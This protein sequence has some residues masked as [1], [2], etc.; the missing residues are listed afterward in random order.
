[1]VETTDVL[2]IHPTKSIMIK[3]FCCM[4]V[5][6]IALLN[7]L[8]Q[9]GYKVKGVNLGIEKSINNEN[10]LRKKL[11]SI[12]YKI[13]YIDLHWYEHSYGAIEIAHISKTIY[14]DIP[15]IIGGYTS[16]IYAKQILEFSDNICY[17]LK[18]DSEVPIL[19]L[20]N[21]I[22]NGIG[23]LE[24]I[25]NICYRNH[26]KVI[27]KPISY[28]CEDLNSLDY[29][30]I[31][32]LENKELFYYTWKSGVSEQN[33]KIFW[34]F[35]GRGCK[36]NCTYCCGS[37]KNSIDLFG[38]KDARYRST[39]KV[40]DDIKRL[41]EIGVKY[42]SPTLDWEMYGSAYYS[43]LFN[44]IRA[45]GIKPGLYLE[46]FQLPSKEF[47]R[48]LFKTFDMEN[49]HLIISPLSGDEEVR[50]LNGKNFTNIDFLQII[51]ILHENN[52]KLDLFYSSDLCYENEN[53]LEKTYNQILEFIENKYLDRRD[54]EFMK[55]IL[56][57]LAPMRDLSFIE[58]AYNNFSDYYNYC[59][60][61]IEYYDKYTTGYN[62]TRTNETRERI[63]KQKEKIINYLYFP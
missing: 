30:N 5:G 20:T 22:I 14:P 40:A 43:D 35:V 32:F 53:S 49:T 52:V 55:A 38:C 23:D 17:A 16:T 60:R 41:Y 26:G 8:K 39:K 19:E 57:P 50:R 28:V 10:D 13:L 48:N 25:P 18:G 27:D 37:R 11:S 58:P 3:K 46:C 45:F 31:D 4:P 12:D 9:N 47:L 62:D 21:F 6:V 33:Q 34:L 51:D 54:I 15:I 7:L 29:I 36:Y 59:K 44:K 61:S 1:M 56:D 42:I 24:S 63:E 2:Y